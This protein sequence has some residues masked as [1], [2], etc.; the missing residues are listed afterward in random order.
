MSSRSTFVILGVAIAIQISIVGPVRADAFADCV[1]KAA[2]KALKAKTAFQRDMRDLIVEK[3]PEFMSVA[4]VNM[5]L[6]ILLAE[7][8]RAMFEYLL[9]HDVSRIDTTNGFG[10]FSNFG[11]SD[12]DTQRFAKKSKSNRE[13]ERRISTLQGKNNEQP[14]WP[15]MREH[16]RS[17]LSQSLRFKALMDRFRSQQSDIGAIIAGCHRR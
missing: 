14:D 4:N 13:L 15:K 10:Q 12:E 3:R 1:R 2:S 16:F 7:R 17:K 5:E 6:Q 11:W 8:R 9:E